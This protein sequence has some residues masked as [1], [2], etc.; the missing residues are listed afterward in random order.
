MRIYINA[1]GFGTKS[2]SGQSCAPLRFFPAFMR[3]QRGVS[4]NLSEIQVR[5][6]STTFNAE[7]EENLTKV[8]HL[9]THAKRK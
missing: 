2:G 3:P 5:P 6:R 9:C 1:T 8:R 4:R 7:F